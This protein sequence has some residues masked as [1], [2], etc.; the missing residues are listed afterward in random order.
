[1][2]A[3]DQRGPQLQEQEAILWYANRRR[4]NAPLHRMLNASP[5]HSPMGTRR[6]PIHG[7]LYARGFVE[8]LVV[9]CDAFLSHADVLFRL[10]PIRHVRLTAAR[11]LRSTDVRLICASPWIERLRTLN[12]MHLGLA[13][14]QADILAATPAFAQLD[15]LVLRGNRLTDTG[16]QSLIQSPHLNSLKILD[17]DH[18]YCSSP[19]PRTAQPPAQSPAPMM[20]PMIQTDPDHALGR[21]GR[22]TERTARRSSWSSIWNWLSGRAP[23]D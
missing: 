20:A 22:Y 5:L 18:N 7:Y 23:E 15:S 12:L 3:D 14:A 1:L 13:D 6:Q 21:A 11:P 4:W 19:P 16:A 9:R 10:G 8:T 2:P 17:L